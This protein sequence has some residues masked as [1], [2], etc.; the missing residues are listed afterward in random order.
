MYKLYKY[1]AYATALVMHVC[2]YGLTFKTIYFLRIEFKSD[3]SS[4]KDKLSLV[5][6]NNTFMEEVVEKLDDWS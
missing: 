6:T 4:S 2:M 3:Y 1:D 5:R